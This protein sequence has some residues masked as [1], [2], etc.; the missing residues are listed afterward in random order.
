MAKKV[1]KTSRYGQ[2]FRRSFTWKHDAKEFVKKLKKRNRGQPPKVRDRL[3]VK[4]EPIIKFISAA[5]WSE[6]RVAGWVVVYSYLP[7]KRAR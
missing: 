2:T 6:S 7:H 1:L 5:K 3:S 4:V